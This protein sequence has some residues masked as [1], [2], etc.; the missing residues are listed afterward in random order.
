MLLH[1]PWVLTPSGDRYH[2]SHPPNGIP[3]HP[4]QK[5]IGAIPLT[6]PNPAPNYFGQAAV[7]QQPFSANPGFGLT[8]SRGLS[9]GTPF[10]PQYGARM[11]G[12]EVQWHYPNGD[13]QIKSMAI[14]IVDPK[15]KHPGKARDALVASISDQVRTHVAQTIESTAQRVTQDQGWTMGKENFVARVKSAQDQWANSL[16][17]TGRRLLQ[18]TGFVPVFP[19]VDK[20]TQLETLERIP[21]TPEGDGF[22]GVAPLTH[23]RQRDGSGPM[24]YLEIEDQAGHKELV[25]DAFSLEQPLDVH[26]PSRVVDLNYPWSPKAV[27]FWQAPKHQGRLTI[28]KI[29][30]GTFTK[31]GTF[32]AA[33]DKIKALKKAGKF[34][35]TAVEFNPIQEFPGDNNWGYDFAY[36]FAVEN[37]YGKPKSLQNLVN[38]LHENDTAVI[39]DKVFNHIGLEGNYLPKLGTSLVQPAAIGTQLNWSNPK[40]MKVAE[41]TLRFYID[42][43]H[44]D[45]FRFDATYT[46]F[47]NRVD[48]WALQHL[49]EFVRNN[50]DGPQKGNIFIM[51]EDYRD[52]KARVTLPPPHGNG[53]NA[54]YNPHAGDV[55]R[56]V[57][58]KYNHAY[59][60]GGVGSGGKVSPQSTVNA[61]IHAFENGLSQHNQPIPLEVTVRTLQGHDVVG[62][63]AQKRLVPQLIDG[64]K[65][66]D[67]FHH[68]LRT[69]R[70]FKLAEMGSVLNVLM[71]GVPKLFMGEDYGAQKPFYFTYS[72]FD[73]YNKLAPYANRMDKPEGRQFPELGCNDPRAAEASVLDW[74]LAEHPFESA[75]QTHVNQALKLRQDVP[76]LW[77]SLWV[78]HDNGQGHRTYYSEPQ[79]LK[80]HQPQPGVLSVYRAGRTF[81]GTPEGHA[82]G[83]GSHVT[84]D[85]KQP[86]EVM[87]VA[88]FNGSNGKDHVLQNVNHLQTQWGLM[89]SKEEWRVVFRTDDRAQLKDGGEL[90][91]PQYSVAVLERGTRGSS[92]S[93]KGPSLITSDRSWTTVARETRPSNDLVR[94]H[95]VL[96]P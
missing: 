27:A 72:G 94:D 26:G 69:E 88:N 80:F 87:I 83:L 39:F 44:A 93:L 85:P 8:Y 2:L 65:E 12:N 31:E 18:K 22:K 37:S 76:A 6:K 30:V 5:N 61:F 55:L 57:L 79:Q 67:H 41:D 91:L 63:D 74:S 9:T 71:P 90:L 52:D 77:Q 82:L 49:S 48:D 66:S 75:Y 58:G 70:A 23:L 54:Q 38:Y 50:P 64:I 92:E 24:Y 4:L 16:I 86:S 59:T 60:T 19:Q 68:H 51:H 32:D 28:Q 29:H 81:E 10:Y 53:A 35:Y 15:T 7:T 34:N 62:N 3:N 1:A 40:A 20:D 95:F 47:G 36:H 25:P 43:F 89:D 45:G 78:H 84:T 14:A 56:D 13:G 33:L 17:E 46:H 96:I 42:N 21:L 11:I 73:L